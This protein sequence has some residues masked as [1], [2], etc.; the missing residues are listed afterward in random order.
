ME[1]KTENKLMSYAEIALDHVQSTCTDKIVPRKTVV[2]ETLVDPTVIK[3]AGERLKRR[4]FAK[5]GVFKPNPEII[6]LSDMKKYY[7]PY[8]VIS[9]RYF[10]DYYRLCAYTVSIDSDVQE[11]ILLDQK[12][13]PEKNQDLT[14]TVKLEGEERLFVEKKAFFMLDK[15][16]HE[17][18]I[19][20]L[21]SAPSEKNPEETIAKCGIKEIDSEADV[22]LIRKRL[23]QRPEN[24]S[25]I[26][27]EVFEIGERVVIYAPRF[28]LSYL[29]ATTYE[30]KTV[31]FDG[32]TSKR[33]PE[34]KIRSRVIRPLKLTLDAI[35]KKLREFL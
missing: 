23:V 30:V 1:T 19:E 26:V 2:Y 29:N 6:Q 21:P 17:A 25:R 3:I 20:T 13:Y 16:G 9:A 12:L 32:V 33:I 11:V 14:K 4:L 15:D 28:K 35:T 22:D 27:N 24:L 8:L 31:E 34:E 7:E 18:N 10:L 5:F